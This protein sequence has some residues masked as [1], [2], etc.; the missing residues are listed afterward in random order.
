MNRFVKYTLGSL[1]A[2]LLATVALHA[3]IAH[4]AESEHV[5]PPPAADLAATAAPQTAVLSG[6]CFWGVQGVFEHVRGVQRVVAGYS[7]GKADTANY[8]TV[9][10]GD[11]GHAESVQITYDPKQISYGRILQIFFSVA[12]DPTMH[13]AQG[14][15][16]GSQY[17]S[18][19][20]AVNPDQARVAHA[21]IAQLDAAHA[22]GAPIATRV[23]PLSGF[24][25]AE[26][27]HQDFLEHNPDYPYI[28]I[29]DMPKVRAL[30]TLFPA[31]Y[32]AHATLSGFK[33]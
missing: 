13:D 25:P 4:G 32:T 17:R 28:V 26:A 5:V 20:F 30:Q 11:T 10:T 31:D 19:V 24:Y 15:D 2:A 6:G 29:N 22:Y 21:Y 14:P 16:S 33:S 7:G 1:S 23:D 18:E 27:Y 3:P 12:L 8:D 9:S